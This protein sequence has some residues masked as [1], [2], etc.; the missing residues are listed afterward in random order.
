MKK[1]LLP[2]IVL[3]ALY[4]FFTRKSYASSPEGSVKTPDG[5][6]AN[7]ILPPLPN[8]TVGYP[9]DSASRNFS[10]DIAAPPALTPGWVVKS[11]W[12]P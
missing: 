8:F 3:L 11:R 6:G 10:A 12:L 9:G 2:V 7:N 1:Y 5:L 4:F